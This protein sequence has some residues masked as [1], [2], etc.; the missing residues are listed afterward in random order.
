MDHHEQFLP[1]PQKA[2][3]ASV[4]TKL[5]KSMYCRLQTIQ[6][7][8]L[9]QYINSLYAELLE[10]NRFSRFKSKID[11]SQPQHNNTEEINTMGKCLSVKL[12]QNILNG[13]SH[14]YSPQLIQLRAQIKLLHLYLSSLKVKIC[15]RK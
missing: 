12:E 8:V 2:P 6:T 3:F 14:E 13:I 1:L 11:A 15:Y 9:F 5:S 4:S 7:R 10:S